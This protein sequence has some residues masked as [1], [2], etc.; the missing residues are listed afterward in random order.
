MTITAKVLE[1]TAQELNSEYS[2]TYTVYELPNGV[3]MAPGDNTNDWYFESRDDIQANGYSIV[4][5]IN[6][7]GS[8]IEFSVD[9]LCD[10]LEGSICEFSANEATDKA[11]TLIA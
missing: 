9:E 4:A 2:Y 7:T 6:E 8:V 10:S 3:I 11:F 5:S 1:V